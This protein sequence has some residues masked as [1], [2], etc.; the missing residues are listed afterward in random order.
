M[1]MT[2]SGNMVVYDQGLYNGMDEC[3]AM[4]DAMYESDFKGHDNVKLSCV[5]WVR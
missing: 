3:I 1:I 5:R 4:L 2:T